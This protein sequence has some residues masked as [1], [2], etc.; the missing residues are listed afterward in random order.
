M[1]VRVRPSRRGVRVEPQRH[2]SGWSGLSPDDLPQRPDPGRHAYLAVG[3]LYLVVMALVEADGEAAASF[4]GVGQR[5]RPAGQVLLPAADESDLG[6]VEG[7]AARPQGEPSRRVFG[8]AVPGR[9][10]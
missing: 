7:C 1:E 8:G 4:G 10:R 2:R 5:P 6:V 9:A 3:Y